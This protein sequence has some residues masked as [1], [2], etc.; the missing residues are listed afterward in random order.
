MNVKN[1]IIRVFD[2]V[3]GIDNITGQ[4]FR[5]YNS[6]L[7]RFPDYEGYNYW[8]SMNQSGTNSYRQTASSFLISAEFNELYGESLSTHDY[9]N[10]LYKNILN[11]EPDLPGQS[12][13][14]GRLENNLESRSEVLMGFSESVE[15]KAIF[16]SLTDYI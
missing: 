11:R 14:I 13:W 2:L 3:T 6:A 9:V 5:L 10:T 4:I 12:Y 8:I 7:G 16:S 1:E 15:N